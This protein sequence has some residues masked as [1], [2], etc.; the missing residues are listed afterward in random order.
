MVSK[1]SML[2]LMGAVVVVAAAGVTV[3]SWSAPASP[4]I[5]VYKTP[6]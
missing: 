6:T 1:T 5:T 4:T 2:G 3:F